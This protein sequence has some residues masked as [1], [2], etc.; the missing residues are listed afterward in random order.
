M[1]SIGKQ[2]TNSDN[3]VWCLKNYKF[4]FNLKNLK[5]K[6]KKKKQ[7]RKLKLLFTQRKKKLFFICTGKL[8]AAFTDICAAKYTKTHVSLFICWQTKQYKISLLFSSGFLPHLWFR[9]TRGTFLL[10]PRFSCLFVTETYRPNWVWIFFCWF[11]WRTKFT[12]Q[13]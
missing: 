3:P 1:G 12:V 7:G 8:H 6:F 4:K 9:W 13:M 11:R 5:C 2:R 10:I